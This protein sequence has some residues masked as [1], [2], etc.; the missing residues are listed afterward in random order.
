MTPKA[1][2]CQTSVPGN[3]QHLK[4]QD[5]LKQR[6]EWWLPGAGRENEELPFTEDKVSIVQDD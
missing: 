4:E 1:G 2:R 6:V 3:G 5:S